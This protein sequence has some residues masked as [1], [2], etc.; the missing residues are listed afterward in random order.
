M[1]SEKMMDQFEYELVK[2]GVNVN[3]NNQSLQTTKSKSLRGFLIYSA[4]TE[5]S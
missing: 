1:K 3:S 4:A 2:E 5:V